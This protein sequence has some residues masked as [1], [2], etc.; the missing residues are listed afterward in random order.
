M[1][2]ENV[3]WEWNFFK[4]YF[5][6]IVVEIWFHLT[7]LLLCKLSR[8]VWSFIAY[9]HSFLSVHIVFWPSET[10]FGPFSKHLTY[11]L[12]CD[13]SRTVLS[14]IACH[15]SFL[16]VHNA[17][18]QAFWRICHSFTTFS[19]LQTGIVF[20]CIPYHML[21]TWYIWP[22]CIAYTKLHPVHNFVFPGLSNHFRPD[23]LTY[24]PLYDLCR[25]ESSIAYH[26]LVLSIH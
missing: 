4:G 7:Y 13:L 1:A 18:W 14:F 16:F 11:L 2:I 17:F 8:N 5:S 21:N 10:K 25:P 20:H 15:H 23:H 6:L 24:S 22:F 9:H 3:H 19:S 12:S 26:H